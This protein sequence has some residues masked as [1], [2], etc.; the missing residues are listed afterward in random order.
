M[1]LLQDPDKGSVPSKIGYPYRAITDWTS[2]PGNSQMAIIWFRL[3]QVTG[4]HAW[5][6]V[7]E[8]ANQ[9]NCF[10]QERDMRQADLGRRG[11]L[12]GSFPGHRG[13]G[14]YWY[15]NWTQKFHLDALLAQ[16]GVVID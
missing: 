8:K 11:A 4:D 6:E 7:A 2:S 12:R 15:M 10:V 14:R 16:L 3:S 5:R 1:Q 9:F 13:M